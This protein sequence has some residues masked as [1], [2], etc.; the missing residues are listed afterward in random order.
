MLNPMVQWTPGIAVRY[1]GSL[2]GLHGTYQAYPCSC[3]NCDDPVFG[4]ARFKLLDERGNIAVTCVRPRS[5]TLTT[6]DRP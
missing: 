4:T 5:L 3:L 6:G 1:H 2:T